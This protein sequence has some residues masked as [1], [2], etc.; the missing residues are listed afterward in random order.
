MVSLIRLNIAMGD[1]YT[2]D[3]LMK[4]SIRLT[5]ELLSFYARVTRP[6]SFVAEEVVLTES[7][8]EHPVLSD[9]RDLVF[10]LRSHEEHSPSPEYSLGIEMGMQR[11]AD[12]IENLIKRHEKGDDLEQQ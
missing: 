1:L 11:A 5:E 7:F 8:E 12:M 10:K 6:E 2:G 9:C 4:D 3:E